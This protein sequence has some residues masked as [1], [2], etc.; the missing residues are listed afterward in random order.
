MTLASQGLG[1]LECV[2]CDVSEDGSQTRRRR[3]LKVLSVFWDG[4]LVEYVDHSLIY[5][6]SPDVMQLVVP[7]LRAAECSSAIR[8]AG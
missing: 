4:E 6:P 3:H 8:T 5:S 2:T 7:G 1:W